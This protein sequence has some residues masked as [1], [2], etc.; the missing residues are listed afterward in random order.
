MR[1][2]GPGCRAAISAPRRQRRPRPASDRAVLRSDPKS[3]P[4]SCRP[5]L[6]AKTCPSQNR[7]SDR[8]PSRPWPVGR[9]RPTAAARRAQTA[10]LQAR[11]RTTLATEPPR[12]AGVPPA[13]RANCPDWPTPVWRRLVA[14]DTGAISGCGRWSPPRLCNRQLKVRH[15]LYPRAHS[16]PLRRQRASGKPSL[17][18]LLALA[19]VDAR[20]PARAQQLVRRPKSAIS[21]E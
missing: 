10:P 9:I 19:T 7:R 11:V 17:R 3:W 13:G 15:G 21:P 5:L 4:T 1:A 2:A 20:N 8:H 16:I 6:R 12:L 18:H 14:A